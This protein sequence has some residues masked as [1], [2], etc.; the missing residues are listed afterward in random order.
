M[1]SPPQRTPTRIVGG[2]GARFVEAPFTGSK[3]AAEKG[4]LVYY[5]GG[6]E[7]ALRQ[8]R[9]I[10]EASSKE[11][12]E[13][14]GVGQATVIK[15]AT[16]M[17]TAASVQ[18]TAEALAVVQALGVPLEKFAQAMQANASHSTTLA[19]KMPKMI[20]RDFEP[21]FSIKH[22]LKDMQIANQLGLS[23]YLDLGVTA[24]ARDRLLEQM[25]WGRGDDDFSAV[26]RKYLAETQS[27][28]YEEPQ[29]PEQEEQASPE[30]IA[31]AP[32]AASILAQ[33]SPASSDAAVIIDS[34]GSGE[35]QEAIPWRRGFLAQLLRRGRQL[36]KQP[37]SSKEG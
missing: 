22:M 6:N 28:D 32:E 4:E 14:G 33:L 23:S 1:A 5:A 11:I 35:V 17:V 31:P 36:L 15:I 26:A 34:T 20:K 16:N 7:E 8:A 29:L 25:Q 37:A 9:P 18:A 27:S 24:A 13:I 30:A 12:L 21:H 3:I 2:R 19:M 10:L